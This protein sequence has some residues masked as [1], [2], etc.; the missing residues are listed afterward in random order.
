MSSI[1]FGAGTA[2]VKDSTGNAHQFG[3]LQDISVEIQT[4]TKPLYGS[5]SFPEDIAVTE[6]KINGKIKFAKFDA[7][8]LASVLGGSYTSGRKLVNANYTVSAAASVVVPSGSGIS[9]YADL[10]VLDSAKNPMA[11]TASAPALGAYSVNAGTGT[12]TF[13]ASQTGSVY[14][15]YQQTTTAGNTVSVTN[16]PMGQAS[17]FELS[18]WPSY[19]GQTA[20]IRIFSVTIPQLSLALKN[21]DHLAHDLSFEASADAN[22][23]VYEIY[24]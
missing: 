24:G 15:S 16:T 10:G 19:K 17:T 7:K 6:K 1:L 22:N 12:Y 2:Y 3:V 13:N 5:N 4:T 23:N 14:I 8:M 20:G 18:L 21:T 11:V 9:Y